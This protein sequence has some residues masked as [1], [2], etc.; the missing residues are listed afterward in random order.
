MVLF[1][2]FM[3]ALIHST[4]CISLYS[5][6]RCPSYC[7]CNDI[8]LHEHFVSCNCMKQ[9]WARWPEFP[10]NTSTLEI[11]NCQA[12]DISGSVFGSLTYLEEL[13]LL[14]TTLRKISKTLFAKN[15][16]LKKIKLSDNDLVHIEKGSFSGHLYLQE[17]AIVNN[18]NLRLSQLA[19][20]LDSLQ[21]KSVNG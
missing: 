16:L 5:S 13:S 4:H 3:T 19:N 8:D 10:L 11:E 1:C 9:Q 2:I 15:K 12:H 20:A 7:T 21:T 17:L 18:S 6:S 14:N